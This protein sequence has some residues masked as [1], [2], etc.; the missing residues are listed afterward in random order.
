MKFRNIAHDPETLAIT[1]DVECSQNEVTYLVN[2]AV[3][4]L[5]SE[6]IIA[7]DG[8][9]SEQSVSLRSVAH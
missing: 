1:F 2:H 8:L 7:L 6:G 3:Q 5:L 4:D 9:K